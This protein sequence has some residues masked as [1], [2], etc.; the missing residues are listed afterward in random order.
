MPSN[1]VTTHISD[2][3]TVLNCFCVFLLS[4][5]KKP[6]FKYALQMCILLK[7]LSFHSS[8]Q[9]ANINQ[10][11]CLVTQVY[12]VITCLISC[13][14]RFLCLEIWLSSQPLSVTSVLVSLSSL[15]ASLT[16]VLASLTSVLG[17]L[18]CVLLAL[19]ISTDISSPGYK[20]VSSDIFFD[21]W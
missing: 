17:S 20:S 21:Y 7:T 13:Y 15:L 3:D 8:W 12:Q 5:K 2:L 9:L 16:S 1:I 10:T 6:N 19:V 14:F 11:G 18:T 4:W